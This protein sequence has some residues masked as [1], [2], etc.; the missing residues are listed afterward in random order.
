LLSSGKNWLFCGNGPQPH[1][2]PELRLYSGEI[3]SPA[4]RREN[5]RFE[6]QKA[7]AFAKPCFAPAR[8]DGGISKGWIT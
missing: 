6:T 5:V 7:D 3:R 4:L 8:S 2:L 1:L